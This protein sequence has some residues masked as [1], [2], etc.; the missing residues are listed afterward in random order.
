[1]ITCSPF[2]AALAP[3]G[4]LCAFALAGCGVPAGLVSAAPRPNT[5]TCFIAQ[6][7]P[8]L[9]ESQAAYL[10]AFRTAATDAGL[11]QSGRIC[12]ILA[13][14]DPLSEGHVVW[15][16]VAPAHPG[17]VAAE[18]EVNKSVSVV[19][20]QLRETLA[21]PPVTQPGAALVEA[22]AVAAPL[23]HP[24]DTLVYLSDGVETH[25]FDMINASLT[26]DRVRGRLND[27]AHRALLRGL[28]GVTVAFPQPLAHPGGLPTY[29]TRQA[30]IQ[31]FWEAWA[32][33]V[34]ASLRWGA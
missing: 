14:G 19:T 13:A 18:H 3:L 20:E 12:L 10:S 17:T 32:Q 11:H 21:A 1:V 25:A 15:A 27:L 6:V 23:L 33:S 26:P 24:G 5:Q 2:R 30:R 4:A 9:R 22:A 16:N 28:Q 8:D 34:G 7:T 31:G 29:L